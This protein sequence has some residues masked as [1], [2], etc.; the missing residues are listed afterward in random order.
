MLARVTPY[1]MK[2]DSRDAAIEIMNELKSD[3]LDLPGM[4]RFINVWGQD[5]NGYVISLIDESA[6]KDTDPERIKA[7]WGHFREHLQGMPEPQTGEVIA[8]WEKA[9]TPAQ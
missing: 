9:A 5:G 6:A 3:I 2:P 7:L 8:H 1:K 4:V